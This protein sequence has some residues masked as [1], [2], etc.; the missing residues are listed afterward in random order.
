METVNVYT[1]KRKNPKR[2]TIVYYAKWRSVDGT[3]ENKRLFTLPKG[4][5]NSEI[6]KANREATKIAAELSA[7]LSDVYTPEDREWP[8]DID[9]AG[10]MYS[11]WIRGDEIRPPHYKQATI[12]QKEKTIGDFIQF[13]HEQFPEKKRISHVT[14]KVTCAW[15]ESRRGVV[16]DKTLV[17]EASAIQK[18]LD[19]CGAPSRGWI[20]APDIPTVMPTHI[21]R[22]LDLTSS[23]NWHLPDDEDVIQCVEQCQNKTHLHYLY[24]L[25]RLG[26]R[27]G[28]AKSLTVG[29]WNGET[30]SVI[31]SSAT[32][33]HNRELPPGP[34]LKKKLD[35]LKADRKSGPLLWH[36][37]D[38]Y[39]EAGFRKYLK[40][41][42]IRPHDLRRWFRAK[43]MELGCPSEIAQ[44]LMG[45]SI[46][47][48][49]DPYCLAGPQ[50]RFKWLCRLEGEIDRISGVLRAPDLRVV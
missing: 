11:V 41:L 44:I 30:L 2:G 39:S 28:E 8:A 46:S 42:N 29:N 6:R 48:A 36:W 16:S 24:A 10:M 50:A 20:E 45:H 18:F 31:G 1:W 38:K 43:L 13:V 5:K 21:R 15:R 47:S 19:F 23:Q 22:T 3:Q 14:N 49:E 9:A 40:T 37:E 4:A 33:K 7:E 17:R 27:I 12:S 26:L 34:F 32:K 25:T 35:F